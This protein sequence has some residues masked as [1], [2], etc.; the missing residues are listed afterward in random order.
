MAHPFASQAR[1]GNKAKFKS[2]VGKAG[3]GQ[4][5]SD[6]AQDRRLISKM[7]AKHEKMEGEKVAG[8]K[9]KGRMDK[10]A[11][12]GRADPKVKITIVNPQG[13][14]RAPP[15]LPQL[16]A[17]GPAAAGAPPG[18]SPVPGAM[19]GGGAPMPPPMMR[20]DGGRI[21]KAGGGSLPPRP[22][23][24]PGTPEQE[25]LEGVK[26]ILDQDRKGKKSGGRVAKARGGRMTAGAESGVGRLQKAKNAAR[27]SG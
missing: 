14:N 24:R 18:P 20:K 17:L 15:P 4:V 3:G 16:A 25:T 6:E 26:R 10:Y 27:A 13:E 23:P 7:M 5:H 1:S 21:A 19:P 8:G 22:L 12:G 11:R 2:I 9:S